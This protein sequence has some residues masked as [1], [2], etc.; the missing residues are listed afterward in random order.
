MCVVLSLCVYAT[1][2]RIWIPRTPQTPVYTVHSH[3]TLHTHVQTDVNIFKLVEVETSL[4]MVVV[5]IPGAHNQ[6]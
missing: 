6:K 3:T 4:T 2:D 5:A 1:E